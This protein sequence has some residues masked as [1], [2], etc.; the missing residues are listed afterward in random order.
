MMWELVMCVG[1]MLGMCGHYAKSDYPDEASCVRALK[2]TETSPQV[3]YK[4]CRPKQS[5]A[6]PIDNGARQ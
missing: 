1:L 5:P 6:G 3:V 4:L 2:Q